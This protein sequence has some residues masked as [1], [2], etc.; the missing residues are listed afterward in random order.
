MARRREWGGGAIEFGLNRPSWLTELVSTQAE[1]AGP[2][3]EHLQPSPAAVAMARSQALTL[4][5]MGRPAA[6][7]S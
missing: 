4:G 7:P 2:K 5:K 1:L 3:Q 6:P